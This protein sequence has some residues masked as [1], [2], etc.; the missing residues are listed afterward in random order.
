MSNAGIKSASTQLQINVVL[1]AWTLVVAVIASWYA[2]KLGRKVLCSLSLIGQIITLFLL[3]ALTKLY[4]S[5]SYDSG[6]Y[7]ALSM[8]FI[9]NAF[10]AWGITPL[11]VLY[12]PEVLSYDIRAV[13]M[14]LYTFTTKLC[15]LFV[16]MVIPFGLN[17]IGYQFYFVNACFDI[18]MVAFV[19]VFWVETRGLALE[20]VDALFDKAKRDF[21]VEQ[22]KGECGVDMA[23]DVSKAGVVQVQPTSLESEKGEQ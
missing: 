18:L 10:Y 16:A 11:T 22:L 14:S 17:A 4:G 7:A 20:E 19:V 15:G 5:S 1:S 21:V 2:D 23:H 9:Y 12:P 8:I 13:G 6:I 3:G